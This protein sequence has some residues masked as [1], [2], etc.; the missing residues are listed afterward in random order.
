MVSMQELRVEVEYCYPKKG[1]I[2]FIKLDYV[3]N[4]NT[5]VLEVTRETRSK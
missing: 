4:P 1:R 3:W 2:M 5:N